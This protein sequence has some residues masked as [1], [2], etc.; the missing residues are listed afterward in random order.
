[1]VNT[2]AQE[3]AAEAAAKKAAAEERAAADAA[4]AAG[5]TAAASASTS[6]AG[7]PNPGASGSGTNPEEEDDFLAVPEDGLGAFI[8]PK[9]SREE[10]QE[11]EKQ[12][13]DSL[14]AEKKET[15]MRMELSFS[16]YKAAWTAKVNEVR[17]MIKFE[18]DSS[19][20]QS[21]I[22]ALEGLRTRVDD[23]AKRIE[24][25]LE[26]ITEL[27][28][29]GIY[30]Y[31]QFYRNMSD[32]HVTM[33]QSLLRTISDVQ[34]N[35][36]SPTTL[37]LRTSAHAGRQATSAARPNKVLQPAPFPKDANHTFFRN[38]QERFLAYYNQSGFSTEPITTQQAYFKACL[39]PM[40]ELKIRRK[41]LMTTP[42][43]PIN[44]QDRN[45]CLAILEDMVERENPV[46]IR[47][48]DFF[49]MKQASGQKFT[50][51][52]T[53]LK[54]KADDSELT[55]IET[56]ELLMHR[57]ITAC[58]DP[59][60]LDKFTSE[61]NPTYQ[62]LENIAI[63]FEQ[64][65]ILRK[66]TETGSGNNAISSLQ[67][68][69]QSG[70]NKFTGTN[71]KSTPGP[72]NR[73]RVTRN[74]SLLDRPG[75]DKARYD[76]LAKASLC[77]KCAKPNHISPDCKTVSATTRCNRCMLLGHIEAACLRTEES[78]AALLERNQ[79]QRSRP[80]TPGSNPTSR[81][82]TPSP[83]A[84]QRALKS[85]LGDA[86]LYQLKMERTPRS[87]ITF[88]HGAGHLDIQAVPD[89][90]CE[91]TM[92]H[93]KV[94]QALHDNFGYDPPVTS[95]DVI[96]ISD[97]QGKAVPTLGIVTLPATVGNVTRELSF[98]VSSHINEAAFISWL[99]CIQMG[100]VHESFPAPV[101]QLPDTTNYTGQMYDPLIGQQQPIPDAPYD[102][103]SVPT[104]HLPDDDE[105]DIFEI[106]NDLASDI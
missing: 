98:L 45:N 9:T 86:N 64:G 63:K 18:K 70:R 101:F 52:L 43:V 22:E 84:Y 60:L 102:L 19:K 94:L 35:G 83:P 56:A 58:T 103:T 55:G 23:Q 33:T 54:E 76:R 13:L 40:V 36:D 66:V 10:L 104:L 96:R 20:C 38:W 81:S 106:I 48:N 78:L 50:D 71:Q 34:Y 91:L 6:G 30:K 105:D 57:M 74:R 69:G 3:K 65:Q 77:F 37:D 8:N 2:K 25:F 61:L 4:A 92:L 5:N 100:I 88:T 97:A 90:G 89:T 29:S 16:A 27:N 82:R 46:F 59:Q 17:K 26:K 14:S 99:D 15:I 75:I 11:L 44:K 80:P 79:G 41:I 85:C 93:S 24:E 68:I 28:P 87:T 72:Q 42:V 51:F 1:M 21:M 95:N 32:Q 7:G 12:Y 39:S 73:N 53:L 62:V 47:R 49:T 67:A 31:E